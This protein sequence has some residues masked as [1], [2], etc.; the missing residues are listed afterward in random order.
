MVD[1]DPMSRKSLSKFLRS[2]LGYDV[3]EAENGQDAFELFKEYRFPIVISDIRMPQMDG[4]EL[5]KRIKEVKNSDTDVILITGFG[6]LKTAIKALRNGA[7]DYLQKPVNVD[8]LAAV[9]QKSYE[10]QKLLIENKKLKV[11]AVE[12]ENSIG[13]AKKVIDKY[14]QVYTEIFGLG[15]IG[16]FSKEMNKVFELAKSYHHYRDV[17][18]LIQGE[19]GTG[20]EVVS[21]MIHFQ[22]GSDLRPFITVNCSAISSSLFESELFGYDTG[23]FT[24]AKQQGQIGKLEL[25]QGGTLFLDEIGDLPIDLQPKLLRAIQMKEMYRIGGKNLIK[26]DVRFVCATNRNL[27]EMIQQGLFR[28]DLFYRLNTGQIKIPALRD[29]NEDIIPLANLFLLKFA[30]QKNKKFRLINDKAKKILIKYNWPGNV[31]ELQNTIERIV[32]LYDSIEITP[33][34]LGFLPVS[35][36]EWS[37]DSS[38]LKINLPDD[39]YDYIQLEKD[40]IVKI[41]KKFQG[42][43]QKTANYLGITRNRLNRKLNS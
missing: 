27:E 32:L 10:H 26:L 43:K 8:E 9:V 13:L 35:I 24:G 12:Y 6:E 5:L 14:Q 11:E 4:L 33:E 16:V 28:Q 37:D 20:K 34:H 30:K 3:I 29:R 22:E 1:D 38:S 23:A 7:F 15:E 25:A 41:L 19:T 31:R 39:H 21:R 18:V 42:N 2:Y 36:D 17:A 40:L